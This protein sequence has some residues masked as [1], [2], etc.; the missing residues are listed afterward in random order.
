VSVVGRRNRRK[1]AI[2]TE[3]E[4]AAV[5]D[6]AVE[7]LRSN[8]GDHP[9]FSRRQVERTVRMLPLGARCSEARE[10]LGASLTDVARQLRV[11]QYRV[12]AIESGSLHEIQLEVLEKYI[13]FLGLQRWYAKWRRANR[14]LV[15]DLDRT[16]PKEPRRG[17]TTRCS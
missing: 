4:V 12:R 6:A 10:R 8:L 17:R 5:S 3:A 9:F 2:L 13:A 7:F 14:A 16:Q 15:A 1:Q 11:P